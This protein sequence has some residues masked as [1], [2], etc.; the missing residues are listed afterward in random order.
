MV[1]HVPCPH[2][3]KSIIPVEKL[4]LVWKKDFLRKIVI[5]R[6]VTGVIG[7]FIVISPLIERSRG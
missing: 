2:C 4:V 6:V 1:E 5:T 7:L 3:G